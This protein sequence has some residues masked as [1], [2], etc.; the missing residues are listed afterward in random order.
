MDRV[1]LWCG[2]PFRFR[3]AASRVRT[4][5]G[6]FCSK[7]CGVTHQHTRHGHAVGDRQ[8]PTYGSYRAMLARC[9]YPS[10]VRYYNYGGRG[11][12]VCERWSD[13]QAFLADM[14]DRPTGMTLDRIDPDG[15]YEPANCRWA[16][17]REQLLNQRRTKRV[18]FRGD[19]L[20]ISEIAEIT[21]LKFA[22]IEYRVHQGW[23]DDMVASEPSCIPLALRRV[24]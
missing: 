5:R 2:K 23:P 20:T 13:F 9:N 3:A 7:S 10:S 22:T 16:T 12:R 21:G 24:A 19:M 11:I 8:S 1:C 18:P 17:P 15:N 4:G 14:G 6:K